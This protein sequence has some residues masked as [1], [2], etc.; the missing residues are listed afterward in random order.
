MLRGFKLKNSVTGRKEESKV[1]CRA[2]AEE[3]A[4]FTNL[5]NDINH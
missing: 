5:A 1:P 3:D 2:V 4:L